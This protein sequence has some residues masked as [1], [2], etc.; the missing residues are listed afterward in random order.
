MGEKLYWAGYE[1]CNVDVTMIAQ[2]P[3][4]RG[5]IS[6]MEENIA[7]TLGLDPEQVNVKATTE[8]GLGFT[9][10]GVTRCAC[11]RGCEGV[12]HLKGKRHVPEADA[13]VYATNNG[14][15]QIWQEIGV[16]PGFLPEVIS[17]GSEKIILW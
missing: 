2:R 4:L 9:G 7:D 15:Q 6:Q 3:K 11:W 17:Y 12:S 1:V 16:V 5:Y 8:E 10:A 13:W 14:W